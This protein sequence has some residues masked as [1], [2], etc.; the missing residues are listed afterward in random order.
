M[1]TPSASRQRPSIKLKACFFNGDWMTGTPPRSPTM[2]RE[3]TAARPIGSM[4]PTARMLLSANRKSATC[5]LSGSSTA[6]PRMGWSWATRQ[7]A[8]QSWRQRPRSNVVAISAVPYRGCADQNGYFAPVLF[9]EFDG[10]VG[11]GG[12]I[13][14]RDEPG[15]LL[16]V[17]EN[18][19]PLTPV[20]FD[21]AL[22]RGLEIGCQAQ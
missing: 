16:G 20:A 12:R 2:P 15:Q 13:D 18:G 22:H 8:V 10:G 5:A 7:A 19:F 1:D 21:M 9:G 11:C 17:V 3:S 4:L 14:E 6:T